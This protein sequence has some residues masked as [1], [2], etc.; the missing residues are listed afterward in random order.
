MII[1]LNINQ[2]ILAMFRGCVFYAVRTEYLPKLSLS[3][4]SA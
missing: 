1:S 2:L 4:A 3:Q